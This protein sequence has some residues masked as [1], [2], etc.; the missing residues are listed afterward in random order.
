MKI[1]IITVALNNLNTI[2]DTIKSV[3]EQSYPEIEYLIIDGGS[4]DGTLEVINH[5]QHHIHHRVSEPDQGIY[6]AMNKGISLA[7]GDIIGILNADDVYADHEVIQRV[8]D[9]FHSDETEACY[10]DL[11]YVQQ[12]NPTRVVRLWKAGEYTQDKL[13]RGWMPP[14]P[15]F[16]I[17]RNCY[18][19]YGGYRTDLGTS[20]DYEL[21]LRYLIHHN[22]IP[23]YIPRQM[24]RMKTGGA[25]NLSFAYRL[26]AHMMDWQAW[27][28][29]N[30]H[31]RW[32]TL[33]LKPARKLPQ[34]IFKG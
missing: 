11:V 7:T 17:R 28:V 9:C 29:N 33:I 8:A 25:S 5:Y 23:V 12:E 21:M 18:I 19:R 3:L 20:A 1:S 31:P 2:A 32:W 4:T 27:R 14:H 22:I 34:W 13:Y 10:G 16:F 26:K 24:V 15:T 30:L 6:D